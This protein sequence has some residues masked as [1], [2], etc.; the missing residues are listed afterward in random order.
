MNTYKEMLG[1]KNLIFCIVLDIQFSLLGSKHW[2]SLVSEVEAAE[3]SDKYLLS[4]Y[5]LG[6]L[7]GSLNN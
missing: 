5:Q 2:Q 7:L 3:N 1:V 6:I 4:S